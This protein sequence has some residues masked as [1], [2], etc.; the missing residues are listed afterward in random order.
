[1]SNI[2]NLPG[3]KNIAFC[4]ASKFKA[5]MIKDK[6]KLHCD[7]EELCVIDIADFTTEPETIRGQ[8]IYNTLGKW[9]MY[10]NT[11]VDL[12]YY[13]ENSFVFLVTD[14]YGVQYIIGSKEKPLPIFTV[15]KAIG[16]SPSGQRVLTA[17]LQ[18][19]NIK[20]LIPV[21]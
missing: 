11:D 10:D 1:M 17:E 3:I 12:S 13:N 6:I 4:L 14:V 18:Y 7:F 15:K 2:Y 9:L 8:T 19:S 21:Y 20:G 16:S 5:E